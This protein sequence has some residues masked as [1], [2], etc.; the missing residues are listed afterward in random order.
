MKKKSIPAIAFAGLL[1]AACSQQPAAETSPTAIPVAVESASTPAVERPVLFAD[2]QPGF[3]FRIISQKASKS[4]DGR[5]VNVV[6]A[7]TSQPAEK[8]EADLD[9]Y[10][11]KQ[12]FR[13]GA[14]REVSGVAKKDYLSPA[15]V[16]YSVS[17]L[18]KGH[19]PRMSE[20]TGGLVVSWASAVAAQ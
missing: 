16:R 10:F 11:Q 4:V 13:E 5:D 8:V 17:L 15:K 18:P 9:A 3:D 1:L 2:Y 7:E 19:D 14:R 20:A 12:G 6:F